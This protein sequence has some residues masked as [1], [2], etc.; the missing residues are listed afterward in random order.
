M[1]QTVSLVVGLPTINRPR[2]LVVVHLLLLRRNPVRV[3]VLHGVVLEDV[4]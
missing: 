1:S 2:G 3:I 4:H